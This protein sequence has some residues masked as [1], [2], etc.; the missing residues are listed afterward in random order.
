MEPTLQKQVNE[1]AGQQDQDEVELNK[2]SLPIKHK[3]Y[4]NP[5]GSIYEKYWNPKQKG[6]K[7]TFIKTYNIRGKPNTRRR[8]RKRT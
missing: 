5:N 8:K 4:L 1:D 3:F 7:S 6:K 2:F